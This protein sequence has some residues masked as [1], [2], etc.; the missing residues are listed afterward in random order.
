MS[1][2]TDAVEFFLADD[3]L[4]DGDN[5]DGLVDVGAR[6]TSSELADSRLSG[7]FSD[8]DEQGDL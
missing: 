6:D 7:P 5:F 8:Q 1:F 4:L 3:R 2:A